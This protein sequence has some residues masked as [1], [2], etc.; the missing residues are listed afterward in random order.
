MDGEQPNKKRKKSK[1]GNNAYSKAYSSISFE[2]RES[3]GRPGTPHRYF[4]SSF[5]ASSIESALS[6]A[7]VN[8]NNV[9]DKFTPPPKSTN[10]S[11]DPTTSGDGVVPKTTMMPQNERSTSEQTDTSLPNVSLSQVI[12]H[13]V[14]GL[15]IVT[16]GET[17]PPASSQVKIQ[18]IEFVVSEAPPSSAGEKRKRQSKLLRGGGGGGGGGANNDSNNNKLMKGIVTPST[19]IANLKVIDNDTATTTTIPIYA[20]VWGEVIELNHKLTSSLD[21]LQKDPLID[22]YVAIILPTGKF[23]PPRPREETGRT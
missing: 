7:T 19:I 15:C 1:N 6:A 18:S 12:H 5:T 14:N 2:E 22:G 23:P 11:N 9:V 21:I 17:L 4:S 13:H 20:C 16:V 8:A 10:D 3:S